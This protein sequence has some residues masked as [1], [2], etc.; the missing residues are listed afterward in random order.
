MPDIARLPQSEDAF[1]NWKWRTA[2]Q[3]ALWLD[4]AFV[5][6]TIYERRDGRTFSLFHTSGPPVPPAPSRGRARACR[7]ARSGFVK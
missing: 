1:V 4:A 6:V 3:G 5:R 2:E 7:A